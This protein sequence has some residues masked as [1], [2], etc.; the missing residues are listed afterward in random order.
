MISEKQGLFELIENNID[1]D[2]NLKD[3]AE[4]PIKFRSF[5]KRD[6]HPTLIL[7]SLVDEDCSIKCF[8]EEKFLKEYLAGLPSYIKYGTFDSKNKIII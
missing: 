7:Y 5:L 4:R 3:E 8:F 6:Y 1:I 2:L